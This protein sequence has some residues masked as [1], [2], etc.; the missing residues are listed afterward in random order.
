MIPHE[1]VARPRGDFARV[2]L[3]SGVTAAPRL[4]LTVDVAFYTLPQHAHNEVIHTKKR[5]SE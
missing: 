5:L 2:M 4:T 1:A 3:A